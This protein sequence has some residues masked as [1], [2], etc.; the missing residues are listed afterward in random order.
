MNVVRTTTFSICLTVRS[1][2]C[3][4]ISRRWRSLSFHGS[5]RSLLF[6][7]HWGFHAGLEFKA[8]LESAFNFKTLRTSLN[9]FENAKKASK[10][11]NL[12]GANWTSDASRLNSLLQTRL[13]T[14]V[15]IVGLLLMLVWNF[16][17]IGRTVCVCSHIVHC[18]VY[19][20]NLMLHNS[21]SSSSRSIDVIVS[22]TFSLAL[23]SKC[24][25]YFL[26]L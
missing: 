1:R 13:V 4:R 18:N 21:M 3:A 16:E 23:S 11:R 9:C 24:L 26:Y 15:L 8:W 25:R 12:V 2:R 5:T 6:L 22:I 19:C 20:C 14:E 10:V 17:G 7:W